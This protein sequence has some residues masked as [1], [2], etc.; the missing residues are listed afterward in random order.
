ML[1]K[2][3]FIILQLLNE[4]CFYFEL[5]P[6]RI[7]KF[8]SLYHWPPI[9]PHQITCENTRCSGL[10]PNWV[11]QH[12]FALFGSCLN[13]VVNLF[14]CLIVL[15][16]EGLVFWVL[17]KE[18]QVYDSYRLPKISNL[19]TGAVYN[20]RHFV[21]YYELQILIAKRRLFLDLLGLRIHRRW[22][23]RLWSLSLLS[24]LQASSLII[25]ASPSSF[26][27]ACASH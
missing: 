12:T 20:V 24:C 23:D 22:K 16:E 14:S 26:T 21:R 2:A 13:K 6:P 17:P 18:S 19:F 27:V 11:N 8:K 1:V 3:V 10:A 7:Q 4:R 15:I 5:R 9:F 25:K